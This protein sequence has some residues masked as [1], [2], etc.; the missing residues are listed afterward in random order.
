[1]SEASELEP[2]RLHNRFLTLDVLPSLG[3]SVLNFAAASGRPVFRPVNLATVQASGQCG[4]FLMLP[5]SNRIRE[6]RF[7]SEGKSYQLRPGDDGNARHGDVRDRPWQAE[8][9]SD[10]ELICTFDSRDFHDMNW[11][12]VFTAQ[13]AYRLQGPSLRVSLTVKNV[14]NTA[15]PAGM[16]MHP[17]LQRWDGSEDPVLTFT[18]KNIYV[19]D[20]SLIPEQGAQ[21]IS[22]SRDFSA[23]RALADAHIDAVYADWNGEARLDWQDRALVLQADNSYSHLVVFTAPDGSLA[24]EP[25]THATDAFNLAARSVAGVGVTTLQ[26]GEDLTGSLTFT[27]LGDW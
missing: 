11:P 22:P 17:Y 16:G 6:A 3:A 27:L 5:Y 25:V 1:M 9:V 4:A 12:W 10:T 26:P 8:K 20:E 14:G 2:V 24:L 7:S 13:A 19:T 18:A 23:G 15:M 21:A